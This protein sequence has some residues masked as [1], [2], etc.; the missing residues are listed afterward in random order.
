MEV[1]DLTQAALDGKIDKFEA[2]FKQVMAS[3]VLDAIDRTKA[4]IGSSVAIDGEEV[5]EPEGE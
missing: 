1:K 5:S 4:E 3:K 2:A